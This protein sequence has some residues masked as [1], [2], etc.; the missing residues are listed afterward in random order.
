MQHVGMFVQYSVYP[1]DDRTGQFLVPDAII[2]TANK[3][4]IYIVNTPAGD[5]YM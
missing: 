3:T 2:D 4:K 1:P 5:I